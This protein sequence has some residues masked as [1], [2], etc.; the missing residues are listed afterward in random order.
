[1]IK[2]QKNLKEEDK[3]ENLH[4][5]TNDLKLRRTDPK[6]VKIMKQRIV[7]DRNE[8]FS[9]QIYPENNPATKNN[10]NIVSSHLKNT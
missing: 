6:Y 9:G 5:T 3:F 1:M 2:T 10:H 8:I 4:Q 7:D